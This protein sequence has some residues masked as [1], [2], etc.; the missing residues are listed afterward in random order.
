MPVQFT[1]FDEK[2]GGEAASC[3][4]MS[5]PGAMVTKAAKAAHKRR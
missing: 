4:A 2:S 3:A 5:E 1:W